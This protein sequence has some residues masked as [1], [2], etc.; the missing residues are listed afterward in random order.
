MEIEMQI[1]EMVKRLSFDWGFVDLEKR[2][3]REL[4]FCLN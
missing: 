2:L 1:N 4:G 3:G